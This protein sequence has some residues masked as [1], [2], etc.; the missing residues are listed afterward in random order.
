MAREQVRIV[1]RFP[2]V[3]VTPLLGTW[4]QHHLLTAE[5]AGPHPL[6]LPLLA[7]KKPV[8]PR[9][10]DV[11]ALLLYKKLTWRPDRAAQALTCYHV[12]SFTCTLLTGKKDL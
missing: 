12:T 10:L 9:I 4:H 8:C 6:S 3:L 11:L 1:T 5:F 2:S 7:K